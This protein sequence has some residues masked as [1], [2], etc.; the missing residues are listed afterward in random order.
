MSKLNIHSDDSAPARESK[1]GKEGDRTLDLRARR[2][3]S[4]K[5]VCRFCADNELPLDYKDVRMMQSFL[6]E[7]GKIVPRRISGNCALHQ[8]RLTVAVKRARQLALVGYVSS[9]A[10]QY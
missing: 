7:R 2:S 10:P 3:F 5:K 1:E 8:R 9:G 4:R 6:S